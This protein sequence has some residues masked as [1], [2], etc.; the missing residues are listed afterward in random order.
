MSRKVFDLIASV[1]GVVAVVVLAV[2][3]GLLV[4]AHSFV[5]SNVRTQPAAIRE[6]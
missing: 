3:G 6:P 5:N 4:W 1:G 2:S